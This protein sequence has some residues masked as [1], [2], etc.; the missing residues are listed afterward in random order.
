VL[1]YADLEARDEKPEFR[2]PDRE[3]EVHL[4]GNM[5]RFMWSMD[6]VKY[7]DAE[8]IEV[9]YG[10]RIRLTMVNDTMME[11]PMHLHGMFMEL[12]NGKGRS[13]P[14]VD[15][16]IVK[17]AEKVSLLFTADAVGPWA[18]HCH[19]LY[20]MEAGMFRVVRVK[21]PARAEEDR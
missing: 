1:V 14:L 17:P 7:S 5:E 12:E 3:I 16:V 10:E 6:G 9:E 21:D 8:P 20:H 13:A 15:T 19:L 18:F 2:P 4:T 11:H